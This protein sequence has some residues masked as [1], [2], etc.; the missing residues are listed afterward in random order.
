MGELVRAQKWGVLYNFD[1]KLYAGP[2]LATVTVILSETF[3]AW[4]VMEAGKEKTI[5]SSSPDQINDC[6]Y[7]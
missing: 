5:Q 6:D 4:P 7:K 2:A 3:G 1:S